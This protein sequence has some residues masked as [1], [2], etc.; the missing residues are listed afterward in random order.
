[1]ETE[2]KRSSGR[3][4]VPLRIDDAVGVLSAAVSLNSNEVRRHPAIC[5]GGPTAGCGDTVSIRRSSVPISDTQPPN[6]A[7]HQTAARI[8]SGRW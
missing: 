4:R 2:R 7:L 6:I 3:Q 5:H 8:V 1:V